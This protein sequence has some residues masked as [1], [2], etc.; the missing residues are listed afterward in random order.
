MSEENEQYAYFTITDS[1]DPAEI[2]QRIGVEPTKSWGKSTLPSKEPEGAEVQSLVPRF[3]TRSDRR[4][5]GSHP[6]CPG[7][8]GP[9]AG[10]VPERIQGVRRMHAACRLLEQPVSGTAFRPLLD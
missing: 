4:F 5:G 8:D 6:G 2:T 10:G 3:T 9:E 1:F 7:A